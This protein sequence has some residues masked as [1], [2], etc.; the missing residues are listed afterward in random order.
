MNLACG[1]F[2]RI[3]QSDQV[4]GGERLFGNWICVVVLSDS[5]VITWGGFPTELRL[6]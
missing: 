4:G 2:S 5:S 6:T 1:L 3:I